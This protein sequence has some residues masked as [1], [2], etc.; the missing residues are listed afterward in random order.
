MTKKQ[1]TLKRTT[2]EIIVFLY[3]ILLL[4]TG[5]SKM[6]EYN[7][8]KDQLTE[9]LG[10]SS[11]AKVIAVT[12]PWFEFLIAIMMLLPKWRYKGLISGVLLMSAFTLYILFLITFSP[13]LPCS[14]GGLMSQLSWNEHVIFNSTFIIMGIAGALLQKQVYRENQKLLQTYYS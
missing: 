6:M 13:E 14:C 7:I 5:T 12:L 4:H 2:I 3:V 8:F 11:L 9:S 10:I 1:S